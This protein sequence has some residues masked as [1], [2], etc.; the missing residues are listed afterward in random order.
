MAEVYIARQPHV[1]MDLGRD[2]DAAGRDSLGARISTFDGPQ[3]IQDFV[4][5][6]GPSVSSP[7]ASHR[8][9]P[10]NTDIIPPPRTAQRTR[11]SQ[12]SINALPPFD[13]GGVPANS[14][15][16]NLTPSPSRSP[17]RLTPPLPHAAGHRRGGSEFIG[18]DVAHGGP[19]LHSTGPTAG[20][21]ATPQPPSPPKGPPASRRGHAH[22]RSGAVSQ[23]DIK[24]IMQPSNGQSG[25]GTPSTP[26]EMP[27]QSPLPSGLDR[28]NS[29][30]E[31]AAGVLDTDRPPSQR[32]NSAPTYSRSRVGFS[33]HV[34]YIPRPLST[35]SS[36]TSSS[37]STVRAN[38][39]VSES[40][41]SL[42]SGGAPSPPSARVVSP[43]HMYEIGRDRKVLDA[44]L[45]SSATGLETLDGNLESAEDHS[46]DRTSATLELP[47]F[48][49]HRPSDRPSLGIPTR[50]ERHSPRLTSPPLRM[51][52]LF[53][54]ET[55]QNLGP[56][57]R[58]TSLQSSQYGRPRTSPESKVTKSQHRVRS[59]AGLILHRKGRFESENTQAANDRSP[60]LARELPADS[61]FSLDDVTFDDDTTCILE[62]PIAVASAPSMPQPDD[63]LQSLSISSSIVDTDTT[64]PMLDLDHA[65][66]PVGNRGHTFDDHVGNFGTGKRRLHSSG[67]TGG[68]M[69]PGM[70]YHRRA[71]SAPEMEAFDRG[72]CG[73]PR[74]G[75]NPAMGEAIEEE[76]E[77]TDPQTKRR[78]QQ[79][80]G[81]GV[82][83]VDLD[84]TDIEPTRRRCGEQ[85]AR[86][87][88]RT[89]TPPT[90]ETLDHVEIVSAEEEP[91][92]SVV[93]KSSNESTITPTP[94]HDP[95]APRPASTPIDFALPT[96]TL[97]HGTTP[98]TPSVVSSADYSKTSF[99]MHDIP[100]I[101]TANSSITDRTTLNSSKVGYQS[102]GSVEDVPSLTDSAST[103]LSGHP[104]RFSSSGNTTSSAERSASLS[105]AIPGRTRPGSSSK[106]ASLAS[107]TKLM[108][109]PYN[110]SKLNIA[111]TLPPES[112]GNSDRK[113]RHRISRMIT[114]WKPKEKLSSS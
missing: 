43:G 79:E 24:M 28:S 88:Q 74:L 1:G 71:E 110:K 60:A 35:I 90:V 96:P 89:S 105:A 94:S 67:E 21:D 6:F 97:T 70:H 41:S 47:E 14:P 112:P 77:E 49:H 17:A 76:E 83:I 75:S 39:S 72:R 15:T 40:V 29:Q 78:E 108:G 113:K 9:M 91:R 98:E 5:P 44:N 54:D 66:D 2:S 99:D 23:S 42:V 111:E 34:E 61:E 52:S 85:R 107:F 106:R 25:S 31:P 68:F 18:G 69:G 38:H 32:L 19:V 22:R 46:P 50:Q 13:F 26:S 84:V 102:A 55:R 48:G 64:C 104:P 93:T 59:W 103:M 100:R 114:F 53:S 63:P 81:L 10:S 16:A 12:I 73:L 3:P 92:L 11:P 65:L 57:Q 30:P 56:R 95:L 86:S 7:A 36:D 8:P 80:S 33:D 62:D 101:H 4:F 45:D 58:P 27:Y 37:M 82:N 20:E 87:I 51:Q 109:G